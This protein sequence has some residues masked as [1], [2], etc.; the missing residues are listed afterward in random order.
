MTRHAEPD[1]RRTQIAEALLSTVAERGLA[2][3]TLAD[4]AQVAG[5]SV[6]LVQRY[7]RTKDELL[8]FGVEY[9]YQ[10]AEERVREVPI[11]PP[12]REVVV[13]LL[14]TVLPLDAEREKELR[15][16]LAFIQAS[17]TDSKMAAIHKA[18]THGLIDGVQEALEGA[19]RAGDLAPEA[20]AAAEAMALVAFVDGL[21]L[22]HAATGKGYGAAEIRAALGT[23][24]DRLFGGGAAA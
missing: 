22:H 24:V 1:V 8:R 21:S 15:V 3:T 5:T 18:A 13:R 12:I 6:G 17:L 14:E 4:V 23:Y 11:V 9:V 7:F 16:W 10:R 19:Q 2:R 20:D